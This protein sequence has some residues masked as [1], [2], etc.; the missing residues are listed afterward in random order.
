MTKLIT[1]LFLLIGF[2]GYAQVSSDSSGF[3]L[4]FQQTVVTQYHPD[5]SAHYSGAKSMVKH[6]D[7]NTMITFTS[8]PN[9][10]L[11]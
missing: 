10:S 1:P 5:F 7:G 4:H 8:H 9:T 3:Q 11:S 6:E 2:V